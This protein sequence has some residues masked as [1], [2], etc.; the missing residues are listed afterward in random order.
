MELWEAIGGVLCL[1]IINTPAGQVYRAPPWL[2]I[3]FHRQRPGSPHPGQ[4]CFLEQKSFSSVSSWH[5]KQQ[6]RLGHGRTCWMGVSGRE[7][8]TLSFSQVHFHGGHEE[9]GNE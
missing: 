6:L 4:E 5:S 3:P 9:G 1:C 8:Y 2:Q 7:R